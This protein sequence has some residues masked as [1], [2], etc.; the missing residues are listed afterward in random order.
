[1]SLTSLSGSEGPGDPRCPCRRGSIVLPVDGHCPPI[2]CFAGQ[3]L[4]VRWLASPRSAQRRS[5]C[6]P[7]PDLQGKLFPAPTH[8]TAARAADQE[9]RR[10]S[11]TDSARE[12]HLPTRSHPH[13]QIRQHLPAPDAIWVLLFTR[14]GA[15]SPVPTSVRAPSARQPLPL[16][17]LR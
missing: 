7:P 12:Q 5:P 9:S 1:M 4:P 13:D 10:G 16:S 14:L 8:V 2:R 6:R 17:C 11:R 15:P 3:L